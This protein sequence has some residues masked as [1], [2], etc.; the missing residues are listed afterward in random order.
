M[1]RTGKSLEMEAGAGGRAD[2]TGHGYRLSLQAVENV[3]YMVK[4]VTQSCGYTKP[5]N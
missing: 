2:G 3:K 5:L 4:M 1:S